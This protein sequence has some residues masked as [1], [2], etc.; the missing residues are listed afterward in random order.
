MGESDSAVGMTLG[1]EFGVGKPTESIFQLTIADLAVGVTGTGQQ[2]E[3]AA[4]LEKSFPPAL[5]VGFPFVI[6]IITLYGPSRETKYITAEMERALD[7]N[8]SNSKLPDDD[9]GQRAR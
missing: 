6:N 7:N 8:V 1:A 4:T 2:P 9:G 3:S 5:K